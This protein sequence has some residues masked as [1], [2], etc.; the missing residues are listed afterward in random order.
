[1]KINDLA[2]TKSDE[3][4]LEDLKAAVAILS[5]DV[6]IIHTNLAS[7]ENVSFWRRTSIRAF[8]ADVEAMTYYLQQKLLLEDRDV[9]ALPFQD[10]VFLEGLTFHLSDKGV[11]TIKKSKVKVSTANNLLFTMNVGWREMRKDCPINE[12]DWTQ[13]TKVT[14]IRNRITHPKSAF[15]L[16]ITDEEWDTIWNVFQW[17]GNLMRNYSDASKKS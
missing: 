14:T 5:S 10:L 4:I 6:Q 8:F 15:D 17:Y 13:F 1:M 11:S 3:E 7:G 9:T 2:Q 16:E 12:T